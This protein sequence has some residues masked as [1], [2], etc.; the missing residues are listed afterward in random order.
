MRFV[1][2]KLLT[3]DPRIYDFLDRAMVRSLVEEH[4]NG[5]KNHR[6]FIWSLISM[7]EYLDWTE[8]SL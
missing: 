8:A 1:S 6:L 2:R 7:E 5:K 4:M 3:G